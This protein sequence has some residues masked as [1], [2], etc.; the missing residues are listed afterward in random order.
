MSQLRIIGLSGTTRRPSRTTTLIQS[1]AREVGQRREIGFRS[2]D[3]A[4]FGPGLGAFMRAELPDAA[5][6]AL[7]EIEQADALIVG[8]PIYEGSYA[9]LLKHLIDFLDPLALPTLGLV[10]HRSDKD[11]GPTGEHL[12]SIMRQVLRETLPKECLSA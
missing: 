5:Q 12:A 6:E 2:Y 9:G 4:E 8:T 1:V 3:L 10:L 7:T 11:I